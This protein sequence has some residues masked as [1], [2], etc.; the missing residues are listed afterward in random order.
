MGIHLRCRSTIPTPF[1]GLRARRRRGRR[2]WRRLC[3]QSLFFDFVAGQIWDISG[4][5]MS[6][7]MI[8]C[9]QIFYLSGVFVTWV[10]GCRR[11]QRRCDFWESIFDAKLCENVNIAPT[12]SRTQSTRL[13]RGGFGL[14]LDLGQPRDTYGVARKMF[15]TAAAASFFSG[16]PMSVGFK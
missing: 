7:K 13:S 11:S 14:G 6:Q 4:K 5:T 16:L 3:G 10:P 1:P 2:A 9:P 15:L 12:L 8:P